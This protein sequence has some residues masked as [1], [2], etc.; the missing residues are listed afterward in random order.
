M[1]AVQDRL[2]DHEHEVLRLFDPPFDQSRQDPGYIRAYPP[3]VRENGGQYTHAALWTAWAVGLL[4]DGDQ[5]GELM[6]WLNPIH[7][8]NTPERLA[9]YRGEPY[10]VAADVSTNTYRPGA[11]GW[12]WYTGSAAW[13]HRLGMEVLLGVRREGET[14]VVDPCIPR[15]WDGFDV[16]W[17]VG[18]SP[19][20]ITVRNPGHVCRGVVRLVVDG[21]TLDGVRIRIKDDGVGHEVEVV[22][23]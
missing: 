10:V 7:R 9:Q 6:R 1:R 11:A 23:G 5:L 22:L 12:T 2:V 3:G 21:E 13:M 18:R 20:H 16:R 14:L 4:G 15:A 19:Y 17:R 8:T